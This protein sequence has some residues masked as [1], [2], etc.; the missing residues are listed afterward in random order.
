MPPAR[1]KVGDR[2]RGREYGVEFMTLEEGKRRRKRAD[3]FG[4]IMS[5]VNHNEWMV[6][7]EV[8]SEHI[9]HWYDGGGCQEVA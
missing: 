4:T 5:N 8:P 2:V 9:T 3:V 7:F 1:L 6:K